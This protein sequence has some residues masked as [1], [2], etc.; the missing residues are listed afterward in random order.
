MKLDKTFAS[1]SKRTWIHIDSHTWLTMGVYGTT[2]CFPP[3]SLFVARV[4][5]TWTMT[6]DAGEHKKDFYMILINLPRKH[7]NFPLSICKNEHYLRIESYPDQRG[8][9][10]LWDNK[11]R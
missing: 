6:T 4:H 7:T 9:D 5:T 2:L 10:L 8:C 1:S 3:A 11:S